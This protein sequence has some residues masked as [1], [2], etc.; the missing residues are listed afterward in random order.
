MVLFGQASGVVPSIDPQI[1]NQKGSLFLTRPTLASHMLTRS[2]LEGLS[3]RLDRS[4]G[5]RLG[6]LLQSRQALPRVG[7]GVSHRPREA[8]RPSDSDRRGRRSLH[9]V[10][11]AAAVRRGSPSPLQDSV[12]S[13]NGVTFL[14]CGTSTSVEDEG[15]NENVETNSGCARG[16]SRLALIL[17]LLP[18]AGSPVSSREMWEYKAVEIRRNPERSERALN[19]LGQEAGSW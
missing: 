10:D 17:S 6:C 13:K 18:L 5:L 9:D 11:A 2:E 3:G 7:S 1:L 16:H 14:R 12:L 19:Q 8:V 4:A 15:G